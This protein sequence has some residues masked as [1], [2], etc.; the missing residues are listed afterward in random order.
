MMGTGSFT[1]ALPILSLYVFAGYR[2]MPAL[3]Q[4]YV[5]LTQ[6]TF[7]STAINKLYEDR[8][9]FKLL[10]NNQN[11]KNN[12]E[13]LIFKE[14]ISIENVY[15]NYPNTSKA[16]LEN[17]NLNIPAKSIIGFIGPTGSGKTTTV[18]IILGLLEPQK[19]TMKIDGKILTEQNS[20]SWSRCIGYVPQQIYLSD[21]SIASNIALGLDPKNINQAAVERAAK[22]ANIHQFIIEELPNQYQTE[23]GERGVRLSGGQRQRIGI[24]RALYHKP[25]LLILDEATNALDNETEKAV[26]EAVNNLDKDITIILIAHRTNTLKICDYIYKLEKG[27]IVDQGTYKSLIDKNIFNL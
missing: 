18:D 5:S 20:R 1:S 11:K 4:I 3:Q 21:N 12:S 15:F 9:K 10:T 16:T 26:M 25:K 27:K 8:K 19:G 2:L 22:I 14:N 24:A 13:I 23:I 7:S 17:I 6:I